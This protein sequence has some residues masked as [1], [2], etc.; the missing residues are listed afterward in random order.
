MNLVSLIKSLSKERVLREGKRRKTNIHHL[1]PKHRK[2]Y[3]M[4]NVQRKLAEN[5]EPE[6]KEENKKTTGKTATG[7]TP[8]PINTKVNSFTS[9]SAR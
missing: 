8:T 7:Q 9:I 6:E 1:T 3:E 5:D 2:W 4:S